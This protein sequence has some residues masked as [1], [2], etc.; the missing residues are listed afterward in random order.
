[1]LDGKRTSTRISTQ[2]K[3]TGKWSTSKKIQDHYVILDQP[4]S[5]YLAHVTPTSCS[6]FNIAQS[7]LRFLEKESLRDQPVFVAGAN[8]TNANVGSNNSSTHNLEMILRKPLHYSICQLHGN[9]L[10][11]K[12]VFYCYD[13]K[14]TVPKT[15]SCPL[16]YELQK[17]LSSLNIV[18]CKTIPFENFPI[19]PDVFADYLSWDQK[20]LYNMSL[21]II[22]GNL[23]TDLASIEPGPLCQSRWNTMWFRC[24]GLY[25]ST[26]Q[27]SHQLKRI[28]NM[29][30]KFSAPM[31]FTIKCNLFIHGLKNTFMALQLVKNL[32]LTEKA[33]AKKVIQ[34]NANFAHTDKV[35][36]AM[37]SDESKVIR[38][39]IVRM[40]KKA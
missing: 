23:S 11:L 35:A 3:I 29:I 12:A 2:N 20:Y 33:I 10:P 13:G 28:V 4:G 21:V 22:N 18:A 30:I 31:R 7:I 26:K 39:D 27:P 16:G 15:F 1:M 24:D 17:R 36:L 8:G 19:P 14:T 38:R 25:V 32:N 37:C 34:R 5:T 9:E 40:I 6:G